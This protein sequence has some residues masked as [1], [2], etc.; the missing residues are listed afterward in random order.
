ML[1]VGIALKV[2]CDGGCPVVR[3]RVENNCRRWGGP[4][5]TAGAWPA[6][7]T[8]WT[9]NRREVN[10]R[11]VGLKGIVPGRMGRSGTDRPTSFGLREPNLTRKNVNQEAL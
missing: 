5:Q 4:S 8:R 11:R 10:K 1:D 3:N 6:K 2:S 7:A 9:A